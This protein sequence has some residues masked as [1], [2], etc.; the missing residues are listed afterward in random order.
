[1]SLADDFPIPEWPALTEDEALGDAVAR[2][3]GADGPADESPAWPERLWQ[4][5]KEAGATRW[6]LPK[7]QGGPGFGRP[8]LVRRYGRI[9][10][11]SL[12]A[13]FLLTQHDAAVRRLAIP[14]AG[15]NAD[16]WLHRI[17]D[18]SAFTTVGISQL[19][20]SRRK[21]AAAVVARPFGRGFELHGSIPWVTGAER[22][23]VIVVGAVLDDGRQIL[24]AMPTGRPGVTVHEAFH[25][26]ALTASRTAEVLVEGVA[27]GPED[28]I[29]GPVADVMAVPGTASTGGLE[30]SALALG[31]ARAA[32]AA[33]AAED[34]EDLVE[35][36]E[37]LAKE[38][39]ATADALI[40]AAGERPDAPAPASIRARANA[41]V[42]RATQAHLTARKGSGFLLSDPAQ[43][44]ARQALFFLVWSCPSPVASAAIRDF[45]GLCPA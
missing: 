6:A 7:G 33:M 24:A 35:P 39:Q 31:Q 38:W 15:A 28:L 36:F 43:R 17:A 29:A 18:G 21:G 5:L 13:A 42:L 25:L 22:A 37:A 41:L 23:D 3:A 19:T 34:R 8:A 20:T 32:I 1:M 26:A 45:A 10:E 30:T 44:W 4:I 11:G 2:L 12:T 16:A 27:I 14:G 40:A 9:A